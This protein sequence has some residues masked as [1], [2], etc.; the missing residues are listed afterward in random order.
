M[1]YRIFTEPQQGASYDQLL[2]MA[3][4]AEEA[5]FGG[6][7]ISDHFQNMGDGT[8]LPGPTD[9]WVTLGGIARETSRIRLGT[10]V[11]PVTFY[12]P[13]P[14]AITVAQVDA[15]SGGR[16]DFG[17]GAGWFE[18]EHTAYGLPFPDLGERMSRMEEALEQIVGLWTTPAGELFS[19]GGKFHTFVDSPALP[20]PTQASHP[21][22]IIGG[23]GKKR[24]PRMAARFASEF[25]VP[26]SNI[27]KVPS[28]LDNVARACEA[29]DRDPATLI[30][31]AAVVL[32]A[33]ADDSTLERRASAIGRDVTE[34]RENG[35]CGTFAE[36]EER[37]A[38]YAE[39][40]ITRLYLQ[41]LDL[42]DL[43]HVSETGAALL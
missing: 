32:C 38:A 4:T 24:T 18:S 20:K 17:F 37:A 15:M 10:L 34:M 28:V 13:G 22:I 19:H 16:I 25:N 26:F 11:S 39:I 12:R 14:L 33:G 6:F 43:D 41:V 27:E 2:A 36:L 21:P 35:F 9:A 40:G 30:T 29:I 1:E 31:S 7:F 42:A 5:G 23:G 3:T 8:G